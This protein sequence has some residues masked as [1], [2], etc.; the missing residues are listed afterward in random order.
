MSNANKDQLFTTKLL[1]EITHATDRR[2]LT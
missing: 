1:K 2:E